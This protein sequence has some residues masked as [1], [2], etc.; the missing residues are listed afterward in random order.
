[1]VYLRANTRKKNQAG[2]RVR[3]IW[4]VARESLSE[5][6]AFEQKPE[7]VLGSIAD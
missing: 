3:E 7:G 1:M 6:V 4:N 5:N 2:K